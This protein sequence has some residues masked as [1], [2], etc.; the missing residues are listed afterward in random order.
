MLLREH[1]GRREQ[2]SLAA[3]VDNL[4]HREQRDDRLAGPDL[5]L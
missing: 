2:N 5:A 4:Q 3:G 1:L